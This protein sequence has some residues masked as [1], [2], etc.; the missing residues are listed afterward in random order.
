MLSKTQKV[1][2]KKIKLERNSSRKKKFLTKRFIS[3]LYLGLIGAISLIILMVILTDQPDYKTIQ[4]G[5]KQLDLEIADSANERKVGLSG[6]NQMPE[7]HGMLFVFDY[8]GKYCFWMKDMHFSI[9]ILW[10]ND[11]KQV[12]D[13]VDSVSPG[14]Y[15]ELFCPKAT[16]SYVLEVNAGLSKRFHVDR[17]SVV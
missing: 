7:Y 5:P 17:K 6:R 11:R 1:D 10:L 13:Q 2:I 8:A 3:Y 4:F 12:I 16:A 9:D 15:P 14:S